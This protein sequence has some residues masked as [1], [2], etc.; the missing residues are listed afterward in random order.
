[1]TKPPFRKLR[2]S[3]DIQGHAHA[4]TFSTF[5]RRPFFR[6]P[7]VCDLFLNCL[8][9]ARNVVG[10]QVWGFVV[11]PEHVHILVF[12]NSAA[13]TVARILRYVK[14][15]FAK[16][17]LLRWPNIRADCKIVDKDGS[18]TFQFWQAGGGYDRNIWDLH[19]VLEEV[20]YFHMNPVKRGL[21]ERPE[22]WAWSSARHYADLDSV[23]RLD[24]LPG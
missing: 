6:D 12:S 5:H 10:F 4:L 1:M 8:H 11:M 2:K 22:D 24:E 17:C 19:V 13:V 18:N 16:Q 15:P 3:Y 9:E 23:F 21:C 7:D 14:A 20:D